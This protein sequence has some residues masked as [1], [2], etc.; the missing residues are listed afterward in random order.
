MFESSLQGKLE[1]QV[2][3]S[4]GALWLQKLTILKQEKGFRNSLITKGETVTNSQEGCVPRRN[5]HLV[6]SVIKLPSFFWNTVFSS[7]LFFGILINSFVSVSQLFCCFMHTVKYIV[8]SHISFHIHKPTYSRGWLTSIN[9]SSRLFQ[10]VIIWLAL[11]GLYVQP[12]LR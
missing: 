1:I 4:Q 2:I 7:L 10:F 3:F 12:W 6:Q 9:F 11:F 5:Q 8:S